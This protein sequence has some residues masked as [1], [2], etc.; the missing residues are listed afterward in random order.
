VSGED[1]KQPEG[2][3]RF[4]DVLRSFFQAIKQAQQQS[5]TQAD[6]ERLRKIASRMVARAAT[7]TG[8][9]DKDLL[10]LASGIIDEATELIGRNARSEKGQ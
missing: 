2:L 6:A 10:W 5:N 1:V 3:E 4:R 9:T 8:L 7:E